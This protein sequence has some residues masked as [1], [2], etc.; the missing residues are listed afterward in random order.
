MTNTAEIVIFVGDVTEYLAKE[1]LDFDKTARLITLSNSLNLDAGVYYCSIGDLS[2]LNEF[3]HVL[4][5]AT[6]IYYS[7]PPKNKW[8]DKKLKEWTEEYLIAFSCDCRKIIYNF[9]KGQTCEKDNILKLSD[10]RKTNNPQIWIAGCSISHGIGVLPNERYGH[11]FAKSLDIPVSF[12]TKSGASIR[13]AADQ[14]LR[15]DIRSGDIVIWGIT[16]SPRISYWNS[17]VQKVESC[18]PAVFG[19]NCAK[20][21]RKSIKE[22]YFVSGIPTY[23]ALQ[24]IDT[25]DNVM[26]KRGVKL[27]KGILHFSDLSYYIEPEKNLLVLSGIYGK[28][29][30]DLYLDIGSDGKHPGP[31]THQMF[32]EKFLERYHELYS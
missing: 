18:G 31:K 26:E 27:L 7:P 20:Y 3:S 24:S 19:H 5:Q 6:T 23:E 32:C 11:L 13:W 25:V 2:G 17:E 9:K 1:A 28:N 8:T 16:S 10:S 15:S 29:L 30:E 14:I 21:I 4:R 12:L 22:N